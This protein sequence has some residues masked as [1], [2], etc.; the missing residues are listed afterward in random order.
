[1]CA[2]TFFIHSSGTEDFEIFHA[3][4]I[5]WLICFW[6]LLASMIGQQNLKLSFLL[7][8]EEVCPGYPSYPRRSRLS[9]SDKASWR[10]LSLHYFL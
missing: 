6:Q 4:K 2:Y 7:S 3:H 10:K 8:R 9:A 1:M 5:S